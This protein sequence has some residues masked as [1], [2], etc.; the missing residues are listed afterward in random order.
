M[1]VQLIFQYS[2]CSDSH[3]YILQ[4]ED[5]AD[6]ASD[7]FPDR[8]CSWLASQ[9]CEYNC[10]YNQKYD[11]EASWAVNAAGTTAVE[12]CPMSCNSGCTL[13]YDS[14]WNNPCQNGG[15]CN[16]VASSF[17]CP[18]VP[19]GEFAEDPFS[20]DSLGATCNRLN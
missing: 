19:F 20:E 7:S 14:C 15:V 2:R 4:C 16:I 8:T 3:A 10:N 6:W 9:Q 13:T 12:A 11:C 1:C 18:E 17:D 5:D